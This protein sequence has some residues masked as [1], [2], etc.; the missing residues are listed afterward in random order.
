MVVVIKKVAVMFPTH[1]FLPGQKH[2]LI[3]YL[4]LNYQHK[5]FNL[6]VIYF[7]K[8]L[9]GSKVL[10][11]TRLE[12]AFAQ[13]DAHTVAQAQTSLRGET[14]PPSAALEQARQ[15]RDS[16]TLSPAPAVNTAQ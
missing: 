3:Y 13:L 5:T 14:F 7:E 11:L 15:E 9:T 10:T 2:S 8:A 1:S 6:H 16:H 12:P 4:F